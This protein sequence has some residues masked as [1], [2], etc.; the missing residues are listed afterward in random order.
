MFFM[1]YGK[2]SFNIEITTHTHTAQTA[3]VKDKA[4]D[5][6]DTDY[7]SLKPVIMTETSSLLKY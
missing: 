4:I 6:H 7:D 5:T 2:H 3:V 1:V